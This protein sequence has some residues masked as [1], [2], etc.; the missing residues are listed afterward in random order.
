[1]RVT[2]VP[3]L[4]PVN[5]GIVSTIYAAGCGKQSAESVHKILTGAYAGEKFVRVLPLGTVANLKNVKYSNYC[6][7]SVH[8]DGRT[9]RVIL[10]SAIDNMVKGAAGQAVQNMNIALGLPEDSGLQFVPPAI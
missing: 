2:F 6:D 5:R 7:L 10:V 9:G 4:L 3:H 8:F 1:M